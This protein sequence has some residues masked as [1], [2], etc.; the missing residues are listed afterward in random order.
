MLFYLE[1]VLKRF[2]L[3]I[4]LILL[5]IYILYAIIS[6]NLKDINTFIKYYYILK[7]Y[8]MY[9]YYLFRVC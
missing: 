2:I 5:F 7:Y 4:K 3:K 9:L 6:T 1:R 8:N